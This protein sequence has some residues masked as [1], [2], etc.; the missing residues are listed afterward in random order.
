MIPVSEVQR[1]LLPCSVCMGSYAHC[2]C[3]TLA[4]FQ[5]TMYKVRQCA[6]SRKAL[7]SRH[8]VRGSMVHRSNSGSNKL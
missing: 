1:Q 5:L 4:C 2:P 3:V 8:T 7:S 6:E